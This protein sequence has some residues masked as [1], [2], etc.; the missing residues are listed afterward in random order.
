MNL[1]TDLAAIVGPANVLSGADMA[2]YSRDWMGTYAG[3]PLV[4]VKPASTE[5]VSKILTYTYANNL[6]VVPVGGNTGL[7]GAAIAPGQVQL[8]LERMNKIRDIRPDS[9]IAIVEAGVVLAR[10]HEATDE[11]GLVFPLFFGARGSAMIGGVLSTNAG[12]SNV[13]RYGN[14]RA[15]CLGL[16][17]VMPDGRVMNLMSELHKDNSGY[18][19]KDLMIGAEG[20]L[21]VITAA[22]FKLF[23]KPCAYATAMV[24][25]RSLDPALAM[26]NQLREASGSAVEAFEFMPK[27]YMQQLVR[28]K[29]DLMP[30]LGIDHPVTILVEIGA[31]SQQA[32]TPNENGVTP[33]N[34]LLEDV[35][36]DFTEH[37]LIED[38][39]IASSEGQR[40]QMWAMRESAAEIMVGL[41]PSVDNDICLPLDK[42]AGFFGLSA[43]RIAKIDQKAQTFTV[44]HLGDG[45]LHYTIIPHSQ[46]PKVQ[47]DLREMVEDVVLSL[48]GSFSAEHGIGLTKLPSMARRKDKVALAV[49]RSIKAAIDPKNLMNPGKVLPQES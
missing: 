14:T 24:A 29:P 17:V 6:P 31:T 25:M 2:K 36:V 8:S 46:D 48:G 4:V 7:N 35:L 22:V 12:G 42:V 40:R 11:H 9:R 34:Q 43:A 37:G 44:A 13:L 3:V 45:N 38:A 39:V 20:T 19:L 47:E 18:A 23:P 1:F 15:L 41:K 26:L 49:M 5:E 27:D 21:G 16:E 33:V 30:P 32:A 28:M 10:L